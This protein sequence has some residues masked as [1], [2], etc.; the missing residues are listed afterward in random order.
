[1]QEFAP[2]FDELQDNLLDFIDQTTQ[3]VLI[4]TCFD[5]ELPLV[6]RTFDAIDAELP[7]DVI[8]F[9][10]DPVV[11]GAASYVDGLVRT[12]G[13][14][15]AE[16]NEERADE[17]HPPLAPLPPGCSD[18]ALDP[19]ARMQ[20]VLAHVDRWLPDADG[21]RF[22]LAL[23]PESIVDRDAHG[24]LPGSMVRDRGSRPVI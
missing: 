12:L 14:H 15:V 9:H 19:F 3:P 13:L 11:G 22:V 4:L 5:E 6:V 7:S 16:A 2:P 8:L 1:M 21:H 17:G 24:R 20:L 18:R 23:L 10:T